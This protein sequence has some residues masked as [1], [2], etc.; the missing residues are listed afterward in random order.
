[1]SMDEYL[2]LKMFSSSLARALL[3]YSPF[4]AKFEQDNRSDDANKASDIGTAIHSALLEGVDGV[5]LIDPEMYVGKKGGVPKGW[6]N[7]KIR[8]ARDLARLEGAIPLLPD[9]YLAVNQAVIAAK[10]FIAES[11]IAGVFDSGKPEQVLIWEETGSSVVVC[12]AR[13]DWWNLELGIMLH[14]KTT[15]GSA[16]PGP[17]P[18]VVDSMGYDDALMFYERGAAAVGLEVRRN[19]ILAVEQDG[20]H[21]AALYDLAP[22]MADIASRRIDRAIR[23][24]QQCTASGKWPA[25]DKRIHSLEPK[26]WQIAEEEER[27]LNDTYDQLQEREGLQP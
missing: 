21:A 23:T 1:M 11:E 6:T 7:D 13:P 10:E 16:G 19:V 25:Y 2:Q 18:R 22:T 27:D 12:K 24:W 4:H 26:P 9:D 3:A 8:E 14:L 5:R 15:A 20:P 17:F